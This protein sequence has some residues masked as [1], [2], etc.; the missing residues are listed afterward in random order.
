MA[1]MITMMPTVKAHAVNV[2]FNE[3]NDTLVVSGTGVYKDIIADEYKS[4]VRFVEILQGVSIIE[5]RA[6]AGYINLEIV[7]IASSVT[8][9]GNEAFAD[10]QKLREVSYG[11]RINELYFGT[12]VFKSCNT[13]EIEGCAIVLDESGNSKVGDLLWGNVDEAIAESVNNGTWIDESTD[14]YYKPTD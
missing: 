4:R 5:E 2:S 7:T 14:K 10:C 8:Y 11:G 9:I 3:D 12:N 13:N 6:F 1:L